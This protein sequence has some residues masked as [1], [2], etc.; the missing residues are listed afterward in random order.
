MLKCGLGPY[1][2]LRRE[3]MRTER[4]NAEQL[5]QYQRARLRVVLRHALRYVQ[6]YRREFG[7]LGIGSKEIEAD[8]ALPRLPV[9]SKRDVAAAGRDMY[10]SRFPRWMTRIAHTGGTTGTPLHLNRDLWSIGNEH[11]FVRRQWDWAGIGPADRCAYLTGEIVAPPD[12]SNGR[13]YKYDAVLKKLVLSTYHLSDS[14]APHYLDVMRDARVAALVAYPSSALILARYAIENHHDVRLRAVLTT[15]E[16]LHPDAKKLITDAFHC[17]V[18]DFYGSAER[19]CYI[20]TC[21]QDTYHIIPEYGITELQCIAP[22]NTRSRIVAT[23]FW[24]LA[25]PLLRYDLGDIVEPGTSGCACGRSFPT[26]ERIYGRPQE[27]LVAPDGRR[28]GAALLTHLLYGARNIVESQLVQDA[29]DHVTWLCVRRAAYTAEDD[30]ILHALIR[31][32]LPSNLRVTIR[33][34]DAIPRTSLGKF[35]PI[36]NQVLAQPVDPS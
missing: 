4:L 5:A 30:A 24:N 6:F 27:Y 1:R 20:F 25:M 22:N 34:V 23:G 10:S 15:S 26:V 3:L 17:R 36:V 35:R 29:E 8:V 21:D 2:H 16:T 18:F 7:R 28:L 19:V 32:H 13:L 11:A 33:P 31:A 9:L 14:V 12:T